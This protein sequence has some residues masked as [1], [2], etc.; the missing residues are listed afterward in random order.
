[1]REVSEFDDVLN[2]VTEL[3]RR[4][5]RV[6]YRI[7]K[8]RFQLNDDDIEDIKADLIDAK[9]IA[10]DENGKVLV[11]RATNAA[12]R[13]AERRQLTVMFCDIVGSTELSDQ[14]D[15]EDLR[16]LLRR[17]QQISADIIDAAQGHIA[18]FLG[19]G[20]L[21]YFGYPIAFEDAAIRA[22][23]CGLEIVTA[24]SALPTSFGKSLQ[25]RVG[26]HTGAV[27]IGD[28]GSGDHREQ[29]ALGDTPNI[30]A[31]LQGLAGPNEVVV[32][33]STLRL[34]NDNFDYEDRGITSLRGVAAPLGIISILS[35]R[36]VTERF[37]AQRRRRRSSLA[38]RQR[39]LKILYDR[40]AR[41][42]NGVHSKLF[43]HAEPG[44]GKSRLV[45]ELRE[46]IRSDGGI[47]M[48]VVCSNLH[49]DTAF[50]PFID[51]IHRALRVRNDDP[52]ELKTAR[53]RETLA[54]LQFATDDTADILAAL[55]SLPTESGESFENFDP[56]QRQ[57][58][59]VETI[60]AWIREVASRTPVLLV[61][62]DLHAADPS[63]LD[64]TTQALER[65]ENSAILMVLVAR[66]EF[67]PPWAKRDDI[68]DLPL[69]KLDGADIRAV[70]RSV[71]GE[72]RLPTDLVA[73]IEAK[74]DG[75][76]LYA[77][78]FTKMILESKLV[79]LRGDRYEVTGDVSSLA[80]PTTLQ[81]SLM[82]R[83]DRLHDGRTVATWGAVIGREFSFELLRAVLPERVVENGLKELLDLD[84]IYKRK[85][86]LHTSFIF[87]HALIQEAAY[88]SLLRAELR[89]HHARIA[90]IL[91]DEF[92][93]TVS[94]HPE[95]VARHLTSAEHYEL[96]IEYWLRAGNRAGE[97]AANHEAV[98]HLHRGL[99][100]LEHL[101]DRAKRDTLELHL[102]IALGPLLMPLKGNGSI[103]V[104]DTFARALA[105]SETL[106]ATQKRFPILFGLRSYHLTKGNLSR[107]HD[108]S[109]ELKQ[110]AEQSG[111]QGEALEAET[112]LANTYLFLGNFKNAER[113]ARAALAI[114]DPKRF[115]HHAQIFGIDPGMLCHSRLATVEWHLGCGDRGRSHIAE[116]LTLVNDIGHL[117]SQTSALNMAAL[118]QLW[119]REPQIAWQNADRSFSISEQC[120]Y[121]FTSA[122]GQV[123]RGKA[124][125]DLGERG[126]GIQDLEEGFTR[127]Q[128]LNANLMMPWFITLLASCKLAAGDYRRTEE[129]LERGFACVK[130]VGGTYA[131]P[132][133]SCIEGDF[134]KARAPSA[135]CSRHAYDTYA[136]AAKLARAQPSP[137]TEIRATVGMLSTATSAATRVEARDRIRLLTKHFVP[138]DDSKD[139]T[140][141]FAL[142]SDKSC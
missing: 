109:L 74:S 134:L 90:N 110:L 47:S 113:H 141:A 121:R 124:L 103:V 112:A 26:I 49:S 95:I 122:M 78:E 75:V 83:L 97:R 111:E 7:L 25:L 133:L 57:Q 73:Q 120:G 71:C 138:G 104:H 24:I 84:I 16:E 20:I 18:Q 62:E 96:A 128:S 136:N 93:S 89:V 131:L 5:R 35:E 100:L 10:A 15:P 94:E 37:N 27:V 9:R 142:I 87:K 33:E 65:F 6:A 82:A 86:T 45:Q 58:R 2:E 106:A 130:E 70:I 127:S 85:R 28:V 60:L 101:S 79:E 108:L 129:L 117:F 50:F 12:N 80:I 72:H 126:A 8:R 34:L 39:E 56:E 36:D 102:Q 61:I 66:E 41:A 77:E 46:H 123:L 23:R 88:N 55:L 43:I 98:A 14:L 48:T 13:V 3:L 44:I 22:V 4:D 99:D 1:M 52:T 140:E 42:K 92:G 31:R 135:N 137:A 76:P 51:L 116:M 11:Y 114:Y 105:L 21:V 107:A 59:V 125:F 132:T 32:S 29:L 30:A 81:D 63:S 64:L 69:K 40:W 17:Y 139:L 118:V 91:I 119:R 38:G 54:T 53:L 19:D 67:S 115:R 68:I